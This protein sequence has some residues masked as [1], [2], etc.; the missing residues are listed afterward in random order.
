MAVSAPPTK[1]KIAVAIVPMAAIATNAFFLLRRSIRLGA[2]LGTGPG[3]SAMGCPSSI[4]RYYHALIGASVSV[5]TLA[6]MSNLRSALER[7][8]EGKACGVYKGR[9]PKI[10]A[11]VVRKLRYGEKLG[12][13][14]IAR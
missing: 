7:Q 8:A 14:E 11:A 1:P 9:K 4:T 5:P 13:A 2:A 10:D 3:S 6:S 12:P